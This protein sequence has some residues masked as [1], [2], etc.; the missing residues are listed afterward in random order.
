MV[1]RAVVLCSLLVILAGF[2]SAS[3]QQSFSRKNDFDNNWKFHL[4]DVQ[5]AEQPGFADAGWRALDLPH[6]WSIEGA[7][8]EKNPAT[9]GGGALPGGMGWY[10]KQFTLPATL[11]R[12]LIYIEF[13]GVYCNSEVWINGHHLGTR[14]NGYISFRY[15]LT[16]WLLYG[17]APN[18]ITVKVDNSQQPNSRWYSGSGIYRN[19]WL[20]VTDKIA[21]D[22]WGTFVTT[23]AITK[24]QATV[25]ITTTVKNAG[26]TSGSYDVV[27]TLYDPQGKIIT[28]NSTNNKTT[29]N[30]EAAQ[31]QQSFKVNNP[32]RWSVQN[33]QLYKAVAQVKVNGKVVDKYE[34]VFGIRNFRFDAYK[35]F[36]LNDEP[37]KI[38][39][40]CNHHD[41]GSLGTAISV[42]ALERQLQMLKQMGCNGIRTSH[43]PPAPELLELCD[44]MGFIV[45]DEAF[46]MWKIKKNDYDYHLAWDQWHA[47]DLSDQVLRDRNHPSVFIWSIGNEIN[48]QWE[49]KDSSGTVIARE[50]A[51][52][53]RSLDSTRPIT[54]AFNS[55]YP[56]N[57]LIKSGAFDLIGYNYEH[58]NFASFH[59]RFPGLKFIATE[60]TSALQTRG[61]YDMPA[62][63][64]RIWPER[65]DKPL[66]GGNPDLTCSAY[67]NCRTPW[68]SSHEDSWKIIK[69]YDFLSG[70]YIWT[71]WDYL[72]EPTPYA[73]PARSS[74]FGIIDLA[75][76]PKD[77]YYMYQSEWTNKPVLH[78]LPHWNWKTGDSVD[79]WAYYNLA[80]EVEL[81][82]NGTSQG[83]RKKQGDE[84]HVQWKVLYAPG[85]LKAV[86]RKDGKTVLTETIRTA[87]TPAAVVLSADRN[88]IKADGKDLSFITVKIVDRDGNIVPDADNLVQFSIEN[89]TIAGVDNGLQTS[90]ESFKADHRKAFNGKCLAIIRSKEKAGIIK[91][92]ATAGG[93]KTASI[94][95]NAR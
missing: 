45:M 26:S 59:T 82:L 58:K 42:R 15:E 75:G 57:P 35:G 32:Q 54:G 25:N 90:H 65:W 38:Q 68:G 72:G 87:G 47:R 34:T 50:L 76:F 37:L 43:N 24:Q 1:H 79:V 33:P 44:K 60:T 11:K 40:V 28:T 63:T 83:K 10:R 66:A 14:P 4:G 48:E 73:W 85:E 74:Y 23:P 64:I 89:G 95:V 62:D 69:K 88:T 8:D 70:M 30:G 67:D 9:T 91:L 31:V 17:N 22:Q 27:T 46:D 41:L 56:D 19:V 71:G 29:A 20:T 77:V 12:K 86:S 36:F 55:P 39:G 81:F 94:T 6:D 18:V 61:H 3:A 52:I 5:G 78:I 7:F 2:F 16:P 49:K 13:D 92:V 51:G 93:L 21:V 84:L 80:D 53:V